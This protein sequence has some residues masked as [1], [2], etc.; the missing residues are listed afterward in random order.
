MSNERH[1]AREQTL[2]GTRSDLHDAIC[3]AAVRMGKP[4]VA[5]EEAVAIMLKS[6]NDYGLRVV[7]IEAARSGRRAELHL[8]RP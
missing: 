7:P 8:R 4:T 2:T 3:M 1:N 6:L 5:P